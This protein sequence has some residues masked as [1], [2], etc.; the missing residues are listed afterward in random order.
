MKNEDKNKIDQDIL[1]TIK[2]LF[3]TFTKLKLKDKLQSIIQ[4]GLLN[5]WNRN[6]QN[7]LI[8]NKRHSS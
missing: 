4:E 1:K 5:I 7:I 2:S 3:E 8:G 6:N